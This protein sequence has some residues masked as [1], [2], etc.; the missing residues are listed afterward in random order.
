VVQQH[1][2]DDKICTITFNQ[3]NKVG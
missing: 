1:F 3:K 2:K